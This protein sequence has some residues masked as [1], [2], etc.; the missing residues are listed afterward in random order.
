MQSRRWTAR[1]TILGAVVAA[2]AAFG[3]SSA[4]AVGSPTVT[5]IGSSANPSP[6]CGTVTLTATVHGVLLPPLGF[7]QFFDGVSTLGG[8]QTLG[9][10]GGFLGLPTSH[11]SASIAAALSVGPHLI[12]A[13]YA[14]T[15]IPSTGTLLQVVSGAT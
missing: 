12:S 2:F 7:V 8:L 9:I 14:G 4:F 6:A 11:S 5:T 3:A 15:D 13:V 10:D 1:A